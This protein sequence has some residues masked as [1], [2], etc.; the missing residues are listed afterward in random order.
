MNK[1]MFTTLK[2][3]KKHLNIDDS[4]TEDDAYISYLIEVAEDAVSKHL[5]IALDDLAVDG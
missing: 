5:D 2:E 1:A 3:T 4:F